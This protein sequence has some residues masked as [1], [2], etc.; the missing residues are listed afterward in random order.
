MEEKEHTYYTDFHCA[1]T[2]GAL[3]SLPMPPKKKQRQKH[4]V[5]LRDVVNHM[6]AMEQR[7]S[8]RIDANTK[9]IEAHGKAIETHGKTI[10]AHGKIIGG[11]TEAIQ[12][13]TERID[14]LEDDL[15]ATIMD[16]IK[17]RGHVGMPVPSE[18]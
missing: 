6:S 8:G 9:A 14:A 16:T 18:G 15:T 7:L 12:A 2:A 5:T 13:L 4:D 1:T 17:I 11:N 3:C 10:E